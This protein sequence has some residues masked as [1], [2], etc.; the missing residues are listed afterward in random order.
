M[1]RKKII[2]TA[3]SFGK[4]DHAAEDLLCKHGYEVVK[5]PYA[6]HTLEEDLPSGLADAVGVIAGLEPYTAGMLENAPA[7]KVISRYGVGYDKVDC[8]AAK[9]AG[10]RVTITPGAN[11][12][13]VADLAMALMLSVARNIS[14]MDASL[15]AGDSERPSGL[16]MCGK[17]VGIIGVG[18][19]GKGVAKRCSGFGMKILLYDAYF[20]DEEFANAAGAVYTDL[21]TIIKEADFITIHADLNESTRHMFSGPEFAKMKNTAVIVNTARGGII[22]EDAL[23]EALSKGEIYGAGLDVTVSEPASDSP[24]CA[25]PN[26]ILTPHAG[27]ATREASSKMSYMAA[28]NAIDVLETGKCRYTVKECM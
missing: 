25:L 14:F 11:G 2:V 3:R 22:D 6:G 7:L 18:R 15:K 9:K 20:Q 24:L 5:L 21:D 4:T 19:I 12:D 27:A 1:E 13:S 23:Y 28:Q 16:E 10:I 17:T 26:C 8:A